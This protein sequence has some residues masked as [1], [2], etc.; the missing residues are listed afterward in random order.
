[1]KGQVSM[2]TMFVND[3]HLLAQLCF[4]VCQKC[5]ILRHR[6]EAKIFQEF[7]Q[8]LLNPQMKEA[9]VY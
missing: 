1:L 7:M 3:R 6:E 4:H 9:A 8:E 5:Q 2:Q